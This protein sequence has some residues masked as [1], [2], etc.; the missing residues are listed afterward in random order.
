MFS[1]VLLP[2]TMSTFIYL[3]WCGVL[4]WIV[5]IILD[6]DDS[7]PL[8]IF[9]LCGLLGADEVCVKYESLECSC[10]NLSLNF[11]HENWLTYKCLTFAGL[12]STWHLNAVPHLHSYGVNIRRDIETEWEWERMGV[13]LY[14]QRQNIK[15]QKLICIPYVPFGMDPSCNNLISV[16][17]SSWHMYYLIFLIGCLYTARCVQSQM[18]SNL[19]FTY[20]FYFLS[21]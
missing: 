16:R 13:K 15:M 10:S 19:P 4:L 2:S 18:A 9:H 3:L 17:I 7:T 14:V 6:D 21:V 8:H 12:R 20:K 5:M 11:T 1:N